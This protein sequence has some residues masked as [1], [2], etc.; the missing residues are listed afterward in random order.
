MTCWVCSRVRDDTA[1]MNASIAQLKF[2]IKEYQVHSTEYL[3]CYIIWLLHENETLP[4]CIDKASLYYLPISDSM[5]PPPLFNDFMSEYFLHFLRRD[6]ACGLRTIFQKH[7]Y[8]A[9]TSSQRR[10]NDVFQLNGIGNGYIVTVAFHVRRGD[11]C[12]SNKLISERFLRDEY[13]FEVCIFDCKYVFEPLWVHLGLISWTH[14]VVAHWFI[15]V[16][17]ALRQVLEP[18]GIQLQVHA[19]YVLSYC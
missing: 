17:A 9:S 10:G 14:I 11:L 3:K 18:K 13:Y 12:E 15:K 19:W 16:V 7:S 4:F 6:A 8:F 1:A 2:D 5:P